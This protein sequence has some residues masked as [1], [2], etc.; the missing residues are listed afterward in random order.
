MKKTYFLFFVLVMIAAAA[1]GAE[2][3][4]PGHIYDYSIFDVKHFGA[5]G[6]GIAN[7]APAIQRAIDTASYYGGGT[8]W[9]PIGNYR[10]VVPL[11]PKSNIM[12]KGAGL[13]AVLMATTPVKGAIGQP[14]GDLYNF[15][16]EDITIKGGVIDE[17]V[18]PR[19]ARTYTP[20]FT[21][22]IFMQGDRMADSLP[23]IENITVKNCNFLNVRGLPVFFQ[24]VSDKVLVTG[25]YFEN[26]LDPGFIWCESVQ[27]IANIVKKGA[28]NGVS[29]S[30]GCVKAVIANNIFEDVAYWGVWCSG[31]MGTAGPQSFSITGNVMKRCGY[32]GV[33]LVNGPQNGTITGNTIDTVFNGPTDQRSKTHGRGVW[34]TPLTVGGE[35]AQEAS[36]IVISGNLFRHIARGGVSM[37][38]AS[39]ILVSGNSFINIGATDTTVSSVNY[40]TG[41]YTDDY[42]VPG[43]GLKRI[44]LVSN[45]FVDTRNISFSN[46]AYAPAIRTSTESYQKNN[47]MFGFRQPLGERLSVGGNTDADQFVAINARAGTL[48]ELLFQTAGVRRWDLRVTNTAESGS[49]AGSDFSI[50]RR[51]DNGSVA[52]YPLIFSRA[53]G[54]VRLVEA[55]GKLGFFNQ[56]PVSKH[57]AI[58]NTTG[59]SVATLEQEVNKLKGLLRSYGLLDL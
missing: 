41:V 33:A 37:S 1:L 39:D 49:Q 20:S 48:R 21:S 43:A 9:L 25:N 7:D 58:P 36:Q 3:N 38:G 44:G 35:V 42:A 15:S 26:C 57:A 52:G 28:D 12:I 17:G 56:A 23:H 30:R 59:A 27:F 5:I 47:T 13:G 40:N 6:D 31:F 4:R 10:L 24:G 29:V 22:A 53:D 34:I 14:S 18:F 11:V 45:S 19:R 2:K 54:S 8:I 32:G 50:I 46:F 55:T 16:V 51:N